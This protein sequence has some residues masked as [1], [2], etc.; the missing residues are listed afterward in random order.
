MARDRVQIIVSGHDIPKSFRGMNPAITKKI[1]SVIL[2]KS[3]LAIQRAV[4]TKTIKRGGSGPPLPG[5]LTSRTG[6][7]RRV[8]V[9][10][11][12]DSIVEVGSPL[13]YAPPHELGGT[14]NIPAHTRRTK[15]GKRVLV[16]AHRATFPKRPFLAPAVA[17]TTKERLEIG[18]REWLKIMNKAK[19]TMPTRVVKG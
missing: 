10:R 14:F 8:E 3:G 7:L 6:Q 17:I 11:V 13:D 16:R 9:N 12:S 15:G 1:Q 4:G 5:K 2:F 19:V 18:N